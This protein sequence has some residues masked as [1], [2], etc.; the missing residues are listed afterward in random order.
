MFVVG[1]KG[2]V[3]CFGLAKA[4][5]SFNKAWQASQWAVRP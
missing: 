1:M 3:A 5:S 2:C 4:A